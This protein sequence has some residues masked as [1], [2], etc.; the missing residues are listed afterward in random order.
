[1]DRRSFLTMTGAGAVLLAGSLG[2]AKAAVPVYSSHR[3]PNLPYKPNELEPY[4]SSRTINLHYYNHHKNY[5]DILNTLINGTPLYNKPLEAIIR[6]SEGDAGKAA[7]H[8]NAVLAWNHGFYWKSMK[9]G[10]GGNPG[11]DLETLI[12]AS[13]G[14]YGKFRE[15]FIRMGLDGGVHGWLWLTKKS[16]KLSIIRTDYFFSPQLGAIRP[17]ANID[18]WEHAFYM[19]YQYRFKDYLRAFIDHLINWDFVRANLTA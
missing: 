11:G 5:L 17:Y 9:P 12:S 6:T 10:G 4:L 1:M 16:G 18:L 13:Y 2:R 8:N 7:I 3:L 19:D 15:E 14:D